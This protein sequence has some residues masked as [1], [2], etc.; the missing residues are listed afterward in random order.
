MLPAAN[1]NNLNLCYNNRRLISLNF[2]PKK[3][4][5][6]IFRLRNKLNLNI[7]SGNFFNYQEADDIEDDNDNN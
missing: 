7:N 6:F 4:T 3:I 2:S 5:L 1:V